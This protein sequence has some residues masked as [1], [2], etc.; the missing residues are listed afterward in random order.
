MCRMK[1][2]FQLYSEL[3][4]A[5]EWSYEQLDPTWSPSEL[6]LGLW[7]LDQ[8]CDCSLCWPHAVALTELNIGHSIAETPRAWRR[9]YNPSKKTYNCSLSH[10]RKSDEPELNFVVKWIPKEPVL[11][12][13]ELVGMTLWNRWIIR[14]VY[15]EVH[16]LNPIAQKWDLVKNP[17][18]CCLIS[19]HVWVYICRLPWA[20]KIVLKFKCFFATTTARAVLF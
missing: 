1:K 6:N 7:P 12:L 17:Q 3:W 20:F 2:M 4:K 19:H 18:I 16:A 11:N 8:R 9:G 10:P 15:R 13:H 5:A 14:R